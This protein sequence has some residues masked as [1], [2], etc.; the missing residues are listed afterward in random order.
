MQVTTT[1]DVLSYQLKPVVD[2]V[3]DFSY[4]T[5]YSTLGAHGGYF[6]RPSFYRRMAARLKAADLA[7]GAGAQ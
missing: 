6:E 3:T 2:A 5:G 1:N 7:A 4:D